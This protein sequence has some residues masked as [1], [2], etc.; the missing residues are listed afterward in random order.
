MEA[1]LDGDMDIEKL[2]PNGYCFINNNHPPNRNRGS[3]RLYIE[4]SFPCRRRSHFE[5]LPECIVCEFHINRKK[6]LFV[7]LYRNP[8]QNHTQF[9]GFTNNFE[10][11]VS[12]IAG[13]SPHCM[14]ITSTLNYRSANWWEGDIENVD[15]RE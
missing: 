13:D 6:Y 7:V 10:G 4:E 14:I 1:H 15:N 9:Q 12:K 5:I 3:V 2:N 11:L 8:N